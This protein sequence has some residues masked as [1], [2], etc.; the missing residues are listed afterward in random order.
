MVSFTANCMIDPTRINTLEEKELQKR[1]QP[2]RDTWKRVVLHR[3]HLAFSTHRPHCQSILQKILK[4]IY[5]NALLDDMS[6]PMAE[7]IEFEVYLMSCACA[8]T[9]ASLFTTN[10]YISL[11]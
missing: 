9:L 3:R 5:A 6:E 1:L 10:T 8:Y 4:A 7:W 11:G 2:P